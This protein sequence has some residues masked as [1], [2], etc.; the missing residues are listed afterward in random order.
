[1]KRDGFFSKLKNN[2]YNIKTFSEYVRDG[3]GK[4]IL[5]ALILSIIIGGI[6]GVFMGFKIK[7][8]INKGIIEFNEPKY[9][10]SI[11]NGVLEMKDSPV[12]FSEGNMVVYIDSNKDLSQADKIED[13]YV[14]GDMYIVLLKDGIKVGSGGLNEE[15]L[16]KDAFVGEY[17]N[18]TIIEQLKVVSMVIIPLTVVFTILQYFITL[19]LNCLVIA[20]FSIIIGI[21]MGLRMKASAMYS[22][23][24]YAGTLPSILLIPFSLIR[25]DVYF[26]TS[27]IAGTVIYVIFILRYIKRDLLDKIKL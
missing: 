5:Y 14:H 26:D 27:F 6:Q 25:P 13:E 22:L 12:K 3:L 10:F 19:L 16:Y 18:K 23:A 11:K 24:V 15:I 7:N 17:T 20:A 2:I 8:Y 21:I 9:D 1:M 4:A